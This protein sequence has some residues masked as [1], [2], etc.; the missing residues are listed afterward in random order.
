MWQGKI[1]AAYHLK[2]QHADMVAIRKSNEEGHDRKF[3]V[4]VDDTPECGRAIV[5]ASKRAARTGG[6]VLLLFVIAPG[7]FQHWLGVED[8]MRQ[9]ARDNAD[10]ILA[11]AAERVRAAA[12]T[13]PELVV[14]EGHQSD[15]IIDLIE[16][17]ADIAILVLAAGTSKEGP[18]PLVSSIAG[19]SAGTFPIPTTIV[20]GNLDDDA[21]DAL[22]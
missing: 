19:K 17:D 7:N 15:E 16:E 10:T 1:L 4:V 21:L 2:W 3:L 18:G 9:E 5:Y 22:A 14:R 11:K 12:R 8:I 20:P 6:V 13:E